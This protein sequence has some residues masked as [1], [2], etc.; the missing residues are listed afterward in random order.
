MPRFRPCGSVSGGSSGRVR[1]ANLRGR[2]QGRRAAVGSAAA[3]WNACGA[4]GAMRR[5][6]AMPPAIAAA[7]ASGRGCRR[8][9]T[10]TCAWCCGSDRRKTRRGALLPAAGRS[11]GHQADGGKGAVCAA[12]GNPPRKSP[13]KRLPPVQ[14]RH[15]INCQRLVNNPGLESLLKPKPFTGKGA[16]HV[17]RIWLGKA[18]CSC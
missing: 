14:R 3:D 5:G 4:G 11:Q 17:S 18:S 13:S 15:R 2:G 6:G 12:A 7:A 16:S 8:Q 1:A 10:P 9:A